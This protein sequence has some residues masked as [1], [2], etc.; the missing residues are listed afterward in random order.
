MDLLL[1]VLAD[2]GLVRRLDLGAWNR[3]L[4]EARYHGLLARL[5][6]DLAARDLLGAVPD[7]GRRQLEAAALAAAANQAALRFEIGR[8]RAALCGRGYPVALLKGG[9]YVAADLA[10]ARGRTAADLDILV[11]RRRLAEVEAALLAAGWQT[12][13]ADSYDDQ[14]YRAWM[15]ELPPF[16][17]PDRDMAL[18]VHHTIFPPVSGLA[19]DGDALLAAARPLGGGLF[20]LDRRD[21][22]L[23]AALHL[24]GEDPTNRLRDLV[25][26]RDLVAE[27][28]CEPGFWNGL[29]ARSRELGTDWAL[30]HAL[31]HLVRLLGVAVPA[32]AWT[33][34]EQR[35][36]PLRAV[37]RRVLSTSLL[38]AMP[39]EAGPWTA[40]AQLLAYARSHAL[41][42]PMGLLAR[43]LW[44]KA[45]RRR[46]GPG[47]GRA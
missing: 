24:F 32:E 5:A 30:G 16:W 33:A 1:R 23:H 37:T 39:E 17:H 19:I 34:V 27:P 31:H 9:A 28:G 20:V 11:P 22:V 38:G 12:N 26:L 2:P 13:P 14:Y 4:L 18:D 8:V 25:D 35:G 6:S 43:H 3:L 21:M 42:M 46:A 29:V 15:H 45:W 41:R 40:T 7:Q 10:S 47:E 36:H 44:I